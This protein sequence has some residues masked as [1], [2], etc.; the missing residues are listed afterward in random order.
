MKKTIY[1]FSIAVVL[2]VVFVTGCKSAAEKSEDAQKKVESVKADLKNAQEDA[3]KAS[4]KA[5]TA[6]QWKEFKTATEAQVKENDATIANLR[7]K[8]RSANATMK[9]DYNNRIDI[10]ADKNTQL[11]KRMDDYAGHQTDWETF[12]SEFS[13]DMNELGKALKGFVV[14]SDKK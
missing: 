7:V 14:S 2:S 11:K 13:H 12:K 6:E 8:I 4:V 5:A 9:A 3:Y 10:L 1:L